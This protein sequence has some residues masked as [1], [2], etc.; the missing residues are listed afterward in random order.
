MTGGGCGAI[1]EQGGVKV[2]LSTGGGWGYE[3]TPT[4]LQ[5]KDEFYAIYDKA[6]QDAQKGSGKQMRELPDYLEERPS[7]DS[8]A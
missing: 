7:F 4:E 6:F 8:F 3:M 1:I 2:L 5:K